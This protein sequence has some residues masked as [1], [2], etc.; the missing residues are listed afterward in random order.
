M[1]RVWLL[2]F[3]LLH[4]C[5]GGDPRDTPAQRPGEASTIAV[6][7]RAPADKL[8]YRVTRSGHWYHFSAETGAGAASL[9]LDA[10]FGREAGMGIAIT[11]RREGLGWSAM[12]ALPGALTLAAAPLE[13]LARGPSRGNV[14]AS[15]LWMH[16]DVLVCWEAS[17]LPFTA[18]RRWVEASIA[19][20]WQRHSALRF[21][22]WGACNSGN[23]AAHIHIGA[24]NDRPR[25]RGLGTTLEGVEG[26]VMLNFTNPWPY[27]RV[28]HRRGL[29]LIHI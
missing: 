28:E 7:A 24:W 6:L 12:D 19:G 3:V 23:S 2:G 27:C 13:A 26:G 9:S 29:S 10:A 20:S 25:T 4:A 1:S 22:Y 18:E 11:R 16:R 17:A 8:G 5:R 15:A 14:L 21:G